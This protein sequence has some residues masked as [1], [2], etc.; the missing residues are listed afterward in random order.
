MKLEK[1]NNSNGIFRF[2][3]IKEKASTPQCKLTLMTEI[4]DIE[5]LILAIGTNDFQFRY[6]IDEKTTED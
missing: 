4:T 6:N 1:E 3:K 2:E 5:I